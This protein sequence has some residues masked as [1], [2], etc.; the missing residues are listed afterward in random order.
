MVYN[1]PGAIYYGFEDIQADAKE[2]QTE[3]AHFPYIQ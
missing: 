3:D 1:I 2:V